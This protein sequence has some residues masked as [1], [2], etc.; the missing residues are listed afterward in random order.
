MA[1]KEEL[2]CLEAVDSIEKWLD[3]Y[4]RKVVYDYALAID[5]QIMQE[6]IHG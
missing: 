4:Y 2:D 3:A 1:E 6:V 5:E